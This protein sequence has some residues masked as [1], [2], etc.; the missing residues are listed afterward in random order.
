MGHQNVSFLLQPKT[1]FPAPSDPTRTSGRLRDGPRGAHTGENPS[2]SPGTKHPRPMVENLPPPLLKLTQDSS[3]APHRTTP[4][5]HFLL[6]DIVEHYERPVHV[7]IGSMPPRTGRVSLH[8]VETNS[9]DAKPSPAIRNRLRRVP[10]SPQKIRCQTTRLSTSG[11]H[12]KTEYIR[13]WQANASVSSLTR[14]CVPVCGVS[15]SPPGES[16]GLFQGH[17]RLIQV[18]QDA[19]RVRAAR[20]MHAPP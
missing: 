5:R 14:E 19:V 13:R 3:E 6:Q 15:Y 18:I 7:D 20:P 12:G 11:G 2:S 17:V 10:W 1:P 16:R 9:K 4:S 8:V